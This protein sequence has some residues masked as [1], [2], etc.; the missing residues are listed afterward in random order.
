VLYVIGLLRA[1][2]IGYWVESGDVDAL[3]S[4]LMRAARGEPVI[5]AEP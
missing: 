2:A 4:A 3:E 1:G 5:S